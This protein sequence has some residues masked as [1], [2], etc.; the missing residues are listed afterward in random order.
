MKNACLVLCLVAVASCSK[1]N[2]N[3]EVLSGVWV[4]SSLRHD[5]IR[6]D[7]ENWSDNERIFDFRSKPFVESVGS[8][9]TVRLSNM[10]RFKLTTDSVSMIYLYSSSMLYHNFAFTMKTPTQFTIGRFYNRK[11]LPVQLEFVRID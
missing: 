3:T 9:D 4:E 7:A 8:S 11:S 6:F 2:E 10:Y 5:T 1:K